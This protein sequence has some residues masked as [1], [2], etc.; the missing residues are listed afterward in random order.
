M[1][2]VDKAQ[3]L[4][5]QC[6]FNDVGK[7]DKQPYLLHVHRV[8]LGTEHVRH[9]GLYPADI[10]TVD[11]PNDLVQAA[12][13]LHDAYEDGHIMLNEIEAGLLEAETTQRNVNHVVEAIDAISKRQGESLE[14]Y[15]G[16]VKRNSIA[17]TVKLSDIQDNFSR[18]HKIEDEETRLRMARKYSLG[19]DI[20]SSV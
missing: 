20:L 9:V 10:D 12:A 19:I 17:R 14:D 4:A 13:W 11:S 8:V 3:H 2:L 6:H 1:R 5:L 18:N 15:Y 16:R 7:H